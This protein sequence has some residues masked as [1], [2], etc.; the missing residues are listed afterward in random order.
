VAIIS[1]V[2]SALVGTFL[3]LIAGYSGGYVDSL[4]M[5]TVDAMLSFPALLIA[6]V[7][8]ATVGPSFWV[9]VAV[10][11]TVSWARYARLIRGE[12]LSLKERDFVALARIA[13]C[14]PTRIVLVH[15]LPNVVNSIVVLATLQVGSVIITEASLSFLGAGI[16]AETPSWGNMLDQ[17][18]PFL[19]T[20]WWMSV[21]P[22]LAVMIVV[23]SFNVFGDWLRDLLDPKLRS[24]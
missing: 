11:G 21:F 1:I 6:L 8:A 5:R 10:I 18:R 23:L 9:V 24:L 3:G 13:G 15:L 12:V 16:P 19:D 4:I 14:S 22:G 7:M 17:G 20:S 2:L